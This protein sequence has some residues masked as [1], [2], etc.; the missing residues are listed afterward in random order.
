MDEELLRQAKAERD[1]L[2]DLQRDVERARIEYHYTIRKLHAGG[3]S[4]REIAEALG[5]SHQ[6]VHQIVDADD[7]GD[8]RFPFGMPPVPWFGRRGGGRGRREFF[9]RFSDEAR[10][11]VVLA[12]DEAAG[13]R[14][15]YLGTEHMLLGL[16]RL[17]IGVVPGVLGTL[18]LTYDAI[19]ARIVEI[20]GEGTTEPRPGPIPFT[21]RA[22]KAL[23]LALRESESRKSRCIEPEHLLLVLAR[24]PET[25]SAQ[26]LAALRVAEEALRAEIDRR[27]AA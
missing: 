11:V 8:P 17:E 20:I 4:M 16:A 27:L 25:V 3:A 1:R 14:H 21:P 2:L 24:D 9:S 18:G 13:L 7:A 19:R 10:R 12:Q 22:K 15:N 26:V 5:L 23:E 6:R